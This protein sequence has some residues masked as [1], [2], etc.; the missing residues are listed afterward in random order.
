[1]LWDRHTLF[2]GR[3]DTL[4][5]PVTLRP[6]LPQHGARS[7]L[8]QAPGRRPGPRSGPSSSLGAS[9]RLGLDGDPSQGLRHCPHRRRPGSGKAPY[10]SPGGLGLTV[11]SMLHT[12]YRRVTQSDLRPESSLEG[13]HVAPGHHCGALGGTCPVPAL[14]KQSGTVEAPVILRPGLKKGPMGFTGLN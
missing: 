6:R 5:G 12:C 1:M 9:S 14:S 2:L 3:W 11:L 8:G 7:H 13:N 4:Q 10:V